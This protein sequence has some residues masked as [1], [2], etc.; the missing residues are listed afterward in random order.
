V[1]HGTGKSNAA[2]HLTEYLR[3]HYRETY[4]R[5]A[6]ELTADLSSITQP[7]LLALAGHA[8]APAT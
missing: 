1:G 8:L 7:Q 6:G 2:R 3:T 5:V 4:Q